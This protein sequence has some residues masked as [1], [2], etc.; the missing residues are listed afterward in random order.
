MA[1]TKVED[2]LYIGTKA[3][4]PFDFKEGD[5]VFFT[6][7]EDYC[8]CDGKGGFSNLPKEPYKTKSGHLVFLVPQT[9]LK[10]L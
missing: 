7:T 6:D 4:L 9:I 10:H 3:D 1:F 5:K 8:S 2:K